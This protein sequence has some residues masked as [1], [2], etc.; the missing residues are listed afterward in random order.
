MATVADGT[1]RD[2]S[3]N[4][5][6]SQADTAIIRDRE[7]QSGRVGPLGRTQGNGPINA[8]TMISSFMGGGATA[9]TNNGTGAGVEDNIPANVGGGNRAAATGGRNRGNQNNKRENQG[10]FRRQLGG[11]LAGLRGSGGT[12]STGPPESSVAATAGLGASEG[13]PTA[14]ENGVVTM[15]FRQV[16][17][18]S[19]L[20][21]PHQTHSLPRTRSHQTNQSFPLTTDQPGRRRPARGRHRRHVGRHRGVGLQDG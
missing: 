6:G 2:C 14:D 16:S 12:K 17:P 7:I 13:L 18:F 5:C 8:A 11:F 3:S 10:W 9:P 1:P 20:L 4:G 19:I 15:T 21:L